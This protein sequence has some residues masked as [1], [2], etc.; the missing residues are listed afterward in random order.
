MFIQIPLRRA[1]AI[2]TLLPLALAAGCMSA[3]KRYEQG[4]TLEARGRPADAARRY[5]DAVRRNPSLAD[6]R[7][8][9]LETGG[10][11]IDQYL[12]E[13]RAAADA[14]AH[15]DAAEGLLQLDDLRRDAAAVGVEL[16][17]PADYAQHRRAVLDRAIED[18][19]DQGDALT[20]SGRFG[21][22]L[23]RLERVS[24]WQPSAEQRRMTDEARL[25]TYS[26]WMAA[27]GAEGRHRGAYQVGERAV[28]ALG[29][30]FPG[31]ERIVEAQQFAIDEGTLRVA[32]LP[33]LTAGRAESVLPASFLR[34]VENDLEGGAWT[35][36]PAFV[37][38]LDPREVRRQ[39]RRY[40][41]D[42]LRYTSEM[43]RL[44]RSVGADMV[45]MVEIDSVGVQEAETRS[46]TRTART[47]GG[48]DTTFTVRSGRREAW[49]QVRYIV[50]DV[51]DGRM[52]TREQLV[53]E[54]SRPFREGQFSGDWR[55]L[56]LNDEDR[57]LFDA[58]RRD[59]ARGDLM[60]ELGRAVT[61]QLSREVYERVLREVR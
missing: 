55:Q 12:A 19:V 13:S 38:V 51:A 45:V 60:R 49:A 61:E 57:R 40:T 22:A 9:L 56:V 2:A 8:R 31:I 7:A 47:R 3:N 1:A 21:D 5:I 25:E 50:V 32:V 44:G 54:A 29:R 30:N 23:D 14:G 27:E 41:L 28:S 10:L 52:V 58:A 11:A 20:G 26:A 18:A 35:R 24:R 43:G 37:E 59:D 4:L 53:P 34:D 33:I 16:P 36:P 48:A 39:A 46:E 15:P 6:A 42:D 17:V